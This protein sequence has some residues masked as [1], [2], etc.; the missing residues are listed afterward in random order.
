[1]VYYSSTIQKKSNIQAQLLSWMNWILKRRYRSLKYGMWF[2]SL[3]KCNN[4]WLNFCALHNQLLN[5]SDWNFESMGISQDKDNIDTD[6][7]SFEET[8]LVIIM[9]QKDYHLPRSSFTESW[10]MEM[11]ERETLFTIN[12]GK[13][14]V[15]K[16]KLEHFRGCFVK[17]FNKMFHK[18]AIIWTYSRSI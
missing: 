7:I 9:N 2:H 17:H 14:V 1:M 18:K 15:R 6:T 5:S 3:K 8:R 4:L 16:M 13:R 11:K 10:K 12:E